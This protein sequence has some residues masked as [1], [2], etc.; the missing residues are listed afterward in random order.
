MAAMKK[1]T[2]AAVT[3]GVWIAAL[4][5]AAALTY[6]ANRPGY[7]AGGGS[8]S[9]APSDTA[10]AAPVEAV[11][12][13][14]PVVYMPDVAIAGKAPPRSRALTRGPKQ[15]VDVSDMQC[16]RLRAHRVPNL[17]LA[18][19]PSQCLAGRVLDDGAMPIRMRSP[20]PREC[21]DWRDIDVGFGN[22]Q[23]CP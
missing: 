21:A 4:G 11:P 1:R 23:M 2:A 7:L 10:G 19:L 22:V 12:E 3:V 9:D 16:A 8:Q 13:P 17:G 18:S 5:S 6:S 15:S 20:G 14:E